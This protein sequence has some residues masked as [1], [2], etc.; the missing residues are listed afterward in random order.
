MPKSILLL[1]SEFP[2]YGGGIST[3]AAELAKA[4]HSR[5]YRITVVA[6][7]LAQDL[8][9]FD[10]T[11]PF[12]IIRYHGTCHGN[13]RTWSAFKIALKLLKQK[14]N[15]DFIHAVDPVFADILTLLNRFR[16]V[17]FIWTVHGSEILAAYSSLEGKF[18]RLIGTF[19]T[20]SRILTNSEYTRS[21]LLEKFPGI[22][23]DKTRVT[24]LGLS[25]YWLKNTNRADVFGSYNID[26]RKK[27][28]LTVARITR[29]KAHDLVIEALT[30]LPENLKKT[31]SYLIVG[32][33]KEP[34][35]FKYLEKLAQKSGIQIVFA[36]SVDQDTLRSIYDAAWIYCMPG[37]HD[38]AKV[39]GLGLSYLEAAARGL[40]SIAGDIGGIKEA[41]KNEETGILLSEIS[42]YSVSQAFTR[43]LTEDGLR[44]KLAE[45]AKAWAR[46]FSWDACVQ[47]SYA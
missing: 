32:E 39:E 20:P 10:K 42:S 13:R 18:S 11:F 1:A 23:K 14:E 31:L 37:R 12:E 17:S 35:Y 34:S 7:D 5:G 46:T 45:N 36:G 43:L 28:I 19:V 24:L 40:P 30:T 16:T 21:I 33:V 26:P 8:N 15:F 27:L 2:P 4:A 6:P 22:P 44:D 38:P 47:A 25:D 41:V 29:R 9:D 3:Y